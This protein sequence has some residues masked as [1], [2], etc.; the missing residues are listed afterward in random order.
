MWSLEPS[1]TLSGSH[2]IFPTDVIFSYCECHWSLFYLGYSAVGLL[3]PPTWRQR[4]LWSS[5]RSPS[6]CCWG[7]DDQWLWSFETD[8]HQWKFTDLWSFRYSQHQIF[9]FIVDLLQ[10]WYKQS[11]LSISPYLCCYFCRC[12]SSTPTSRSQLPPCWRWSWPWWAWRPSCP[13][14]SRTPPLP[15]TSSSWSGF[16]T[17]MMLFAAT[18]RSLGK[19]QAACL[20]S[21]SNCI[22]LAKQAYSLGGSG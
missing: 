16:V 15:S 7:S 4:W 6:P 22:Y 10:V 8:N 12:W 19:T 9:V 18:L 17:S 14:S 3:Q 5:S 21:W 2:L 13:S 1:I 20:P 11:L